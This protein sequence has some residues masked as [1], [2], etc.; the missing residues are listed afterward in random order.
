VSVSVASL[1]VIR[2]EFASDSLAI[3]LNCSKSRVCII[4]E[5]AAVHPFGEFR[6]LLRLVYCKERIYSSLR[7][8][9]SEQA[10]RTCRT[11]IAPKPQRHRG[12]NTVNIFLS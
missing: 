8:F 1:F 11:V 3:P 12:L 10:R 6:I 7:S 2:R 4:K 5:I 9:H